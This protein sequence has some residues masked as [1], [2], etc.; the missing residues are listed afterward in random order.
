V[1]VIFRKHAFA[2]MMAL[3]LI[4]FNLQLSQGNS[5]FTSLVLRGVNAVFG[6]YCFV[7]FFKPTFLTLT[8]REIEGRRQSQQLADTCFFVLSLPAVPFSIAYLAKVGLIPGLP[9]SAAPHLMAVAQNIG[10]V[11][12]GFGLFLVVAIKSARN[13]EGERLAWQWVVRCVYGYVL[14]VTCFTLLTILDRP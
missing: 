14:I 13:L 9:L 1:N 10:L 5:D 4:V 8:G 12:Y 3:A 7:L 6:I 2:A 11:T